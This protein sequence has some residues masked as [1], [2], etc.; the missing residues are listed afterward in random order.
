MS[1]GWKA[2]SEGES[3]YEED[4]CMG[5]HEVVHGF[6]RW[7]ISLCTYIPRRNGLPVRRCL[8]QR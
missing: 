4:T 7:P 3:G 6:G 1:C 5:V 8:K 2:E